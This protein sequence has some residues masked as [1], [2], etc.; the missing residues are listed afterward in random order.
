[1]RSNVSLNNVRKDNRYLA[2]FITTKSEIVVPIK[3]NNIVIGEIDIDSDKKMHLI[4]KTVY[5]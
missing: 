5:S 1:M 3:R 4:I 2:C